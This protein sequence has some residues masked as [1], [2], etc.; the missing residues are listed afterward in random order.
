MES[1]PTNT[2]IDF[3]EKIIQALK[4]AVKKLVE[5]SAA[6]NES[7]VIRDKDGK[8]KRIPA[9]DLLAEVKE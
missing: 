6:K 5:E 1:K 7:L 8:I 4:K 2:T 3:P 9:K